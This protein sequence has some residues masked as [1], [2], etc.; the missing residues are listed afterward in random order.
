M[1]LRRRSVRWQLD[2]EAGLEFKGN[3]SGVNCVLHDISYNGA[4][5]SL[6]EK[7]ARDTIL[8]IKICLSAGIELC[9]EAWVIWHKYIEDVNVYGLYFTKIKDSDK[10]KISKFIRRDF[11]PQLATKWWRDSTEKEG[12]EHMDDRRIFE[13]FQTSF[14]VRFIDLKENREGAAQT[15]DIS[16]KG[17]GFM[18]KDELKLRTPLELWLQVPD[19]GE[20]LYTRGYVAWSRM[21]TPNEFRIGV[22]LE[23]AD[24]MGMSRVLRAV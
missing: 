18:V 1:Q 17:I 6:D 4:R 15:Q 23:R 14:P 12:G 19:K 9:V 10:E 20:P 16:A 11:T 3:A 8:E 21:V 5:I 13:R 7:L 22:N 2:C 24:L